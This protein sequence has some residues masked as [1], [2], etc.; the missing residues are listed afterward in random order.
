MRVRTPQLRIRDLATRAK[1]A[2]LNCV[3]PIQRTVRV[4]PASRGLYR[5]VLL[6]RRLSTMCRPHVALRRANPEMKPRRHYLTFS[7][8]TLFVLT[9]AIALWLGVVVNRAREQ[10]EAV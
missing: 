1:T 8:R 3:L 6:G 5:S 9:G 4:G 2:W 7:L 10:R